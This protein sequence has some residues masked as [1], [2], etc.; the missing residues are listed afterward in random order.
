MSSPAVPWYHL[1]KA[2]TP[3]LRFAVG[4]LGY[5][6]G[7]IL[8]L[9]GQSAAWAGRTAAWWWRTRQLRYLVQG[10]PALL[11]LGLL[12]ACACV[13]QFATAHTAVANYRMAAESAVQ[14]EDYETAKI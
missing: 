5:H 7:Y 13:W 3:R 10:L 6:T 4:W 2:L 9:A 8:F 11:A 14:A 1:K 12:G